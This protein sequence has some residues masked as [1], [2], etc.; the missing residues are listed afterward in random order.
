MRWGEAE[1]LVHSAAAVDLSFLNSGTAPLL[2]SHNRHDGLRAVIGV[3]IRAWI[4]DKR[5]WVEAR[6]SNRAAAQEV[7][8]DV[9]DGV[10]QNVSVGY[11]VT[12]YVRDENSNPPSYRVT[13]WRPKEA[14]FVAIPADAT[15]GMG[16]SEIAMES[17]M[18][19]K[20]LPLPGQPP[21]TPAV[22][23]TGPTP[24]E[25]GAEI[26]D[27]SREINA[28]AATHNQRDLA[29][30]FID[31]AMRAGSVPSLATFRGKLRA[32]VPSDT[33]LVNRDIGLT[34]TES[35]SFSLVRL[36]A[37]MA[38]NA[39]D[40]DRS[41]AAFE[42]EAC[43]AA[44]RTAEG[45]T[46]GFRLPTDIMNAWGNPLVAGQSRAAMGTGGNPNVQSVDHLSDRFIDNLRRASTVL[47]MGVTMLSGLDGNVEIPGGDVNATALWLASEDANAA[48]T[49]PTFRKVTMSI[50]DVAAYTDLTRRM[51]L[52]S[53]IDI[54]MYVRAQLT[55]AMVEAID[56]AGLEGSGAAG[57]PRGLKNTVGIGGVTFAAA[58]P[59]WGEI[60]DLE[61]DVAD[62]NALFGNTG[63]LGT[64][65]MRGH[66]KKTLKTA[67]VGGYIMDSNSDGLNGHRYAAST[68]VT[69][70]DLY[71]GNWSDMLM[72]LWGSLDL[73][74]DTS[75]KFLAGGVRLRAIQS[76]DFGVA[77]VGSFSL[78]NDGV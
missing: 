71:F 40:G 35:R 65:N 34:P 62:A 52:Q 25:R 45:A 28:L 30:A 31:E 57:I 1:I 8:H 21:I 33:P 68:G 56:I 72:G 5:L 42:R 67:G 75:A 41:A 37:S 77:R 48:E 63:Y 78:G 26:A 47:Q 32:V 66:F 23:V 43:E 9:L 46:R 49:V 27:A 29:D 4:K 19:P 18:D 15:V 13:K 36:A 10:I 38:E 6:F 55:R 61:T 11:D 76:V 2:D 74:R 58:N 69:S 44:A 12:E 53:T 59:T 50:K 20:T 73:D 39:T 14:S 51:L 64:T 60:V 3:V 24:A 16:R 7:Y 70:G 54:E 17:P 22:V